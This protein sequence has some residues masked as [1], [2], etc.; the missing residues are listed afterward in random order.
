MCV[1]G[2]LT[3]NAWK[4]DTS[5]FESVMELKSYFNIVITG[6]RHLTNVALFFNVLEPIAHY[7]PVTTKQLSIKLIVDSREL[8]WGY[9][10]AV[11]NQWRVHSWL[12]AR[13]VIILPESIHS[14]VVYSRWFPH[15]SRINA[16]FGWPTDE[17]IGDNNI[18]YNFTIF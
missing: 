15:Y 16:V 4:Y 12:N 17:I 1:N 10:L 18:V 14:L 11:N 6:A 7:L 13:G 3:L 2:L 5:N 9:T 8:L